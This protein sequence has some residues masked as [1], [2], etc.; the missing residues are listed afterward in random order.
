MPQLSCNAIIYF[1][2][3]TNYGAIKESNIFILATQQL[4]CQGAFQSIYQ[5]KISSFRKKKIPLKQ[6]MNLMNGHR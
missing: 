2:T 3:G 4:H 6:E 1:N 5:I